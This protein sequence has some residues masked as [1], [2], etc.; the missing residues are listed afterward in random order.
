MRIR[1]IKQRL[2]IRTTICKITAMDK[3]VQQTDDRRGKNGT[4]SGF[5]WGRSVNVRVEGRFWKLDGGKV[6]DT[7]R[8]R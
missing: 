7:E 6:I 3:E 5:V 2:N 4:E 8:G 1:I